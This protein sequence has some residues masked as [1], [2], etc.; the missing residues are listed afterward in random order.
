[1]IDARTA[2]G[3][4]FV[5]VHD[6]RGGLSGYA[7]EYE[8]PL[9]D[10]ALFTG[11][12]GHGIAEAASD[13]IYVS[14]DAGSEL[15]CTGTASYVTTTDQGWKID[16]TGSWQQVP[17][18]AV[19]AA[20]R[21]TDAGWAEWSLRGPRVKPDR[22]AAVDLW[23]WVLGFNTLRLR[24]RPDLLAVVPSKL[25]YVGAWQWDSYFIARGLRHPDPALARDQLLLVTDVQGRDGLLPDVVYD[26]GVLATS[27]VLPAVEAARLAESPWRS[28][29]RPP[30]V[31]LTKP[32]L[33]A[34]AVDALDD[35]APDQD[36]RAEMLSRSRANHDWWFRVSSS[37]GVPYYLHPYSSGLDDSPTFDVGPAHPTADL[38]A[39]LADG[40]ARLAGT[41]FA[42]DPARRVWL[43][44]AL[45][46]CQPTETVIDLLGLHG[47]LLPRSTVH[48]LAGR[49]RDPHDFGGRT[50]IPTVSRTHPSFDSAHMWRGPVWVNTNVL[51]AEGLR[52]SG[53]GDLAHAIETATLDLVEDA[54][55]WEYFD[56]DSGRPASG[57][58][59]H[60]SWSA[61]LA[62][63]L[64]VREAA[65]G[66]DQR[67]D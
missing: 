17:V 33:L 59:S 2:I 6:D 43:A 3:S 56:A 27:A 21:N 29:D 58:V 28:H 14:A 44:E 47:G 60:F 9:R 61:A 62:L 42:G 35:L 39:Y 54:G 53:R 1:M 5:L 22:Q 12:S 34:W 52:S 20:K 36:F 23:W 45:H 50:A 19:D 63:D 4:R 67:A 37:G 18:E 32:P 11:L 46:A 66:A 31:P 55:P 15:R 65:D 13:G 25:G 16:E 40:E 7:V 51:V 49:L 41:P 64:A 8:R 48:R 26:D 57:A 10:S 38:L 24:S 30:V